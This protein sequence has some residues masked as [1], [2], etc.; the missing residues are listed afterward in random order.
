MKIT[1][2]QLG[3]HSGILT[4]QTTIVE[5]CDETTALLTVLVRDKCTVHEGDVFVVHREGEDCPEFELAKAMLERR[6]P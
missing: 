2:A 6:T 3:H 4:L 1:V 5:A